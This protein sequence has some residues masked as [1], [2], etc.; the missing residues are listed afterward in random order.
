METSDKSAGPALLN[1]APCSSG[2]DGAA[3]RGSW[4]TELDPVVPMLFPKDGPVSGVGMQQ[5]GVAPAKEER[6]EFR[7]EGAG[8]G[9]IERHN[10]FHVLT[11]CD[12]RPLV[13]GAAEEGR[14]V[15]LEEVVAVFPRKE[16]S[17]FPRKARKAGNA[18]AEEGKRERSNGRKPEAESH[19]PGRDAGDGENGRVDRGVEGKEGGKIGLELGDASQVAD[20]GGSALADEGKSRPTG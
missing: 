8:G 17:C 10:R 18:E 16:A 6:M 19:F 3:T 2:G 4:G 1:E 13:P 11:H 20:P 9:E 12:G 15:L 5:R 7:K 14:M